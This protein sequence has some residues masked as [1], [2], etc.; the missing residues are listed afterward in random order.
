VRDLTCTREDTKA[1]ERQA[2]QRLST[3]PLRHGRLYTSG[4][5]KWTKA[6]TGRLATFKFEAAVPQ[7][8]FQEHVDTVA[9]RFSQVAALE[10]GMV[11]VLD[12]FCLRAVF[13]AASSRSGGHRAT[14]R[15]CTAE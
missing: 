9:H 7:I 10:A 13:K 11:S 6:H 1:L 5:V 8:V 14:R 4:K 2:K 12:H 15:Q 3:F